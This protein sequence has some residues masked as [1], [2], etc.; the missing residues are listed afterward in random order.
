MRKLNFVSGLLAGLA[1]AIVA[2]ILVSHKPAVEPALPQSSNRITS[3]NQG[4]DVYR[5]SVD[6]IQYIVVVSD[7][8]GVAITKH[9]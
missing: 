2:F 7:N 5:V 1:L 8:G 6:N 3:V 9:K 4:T